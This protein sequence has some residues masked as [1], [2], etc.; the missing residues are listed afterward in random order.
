MVSGDY[1]VET[2]EQIELAYD[3]AG[4]GS[5][6]LA[7]IVDSALIALAESALFFALAQI[8]GAMEFAESVLIAIGAALGFAI[9]WGYY[10]A[11]ELTW[12]GQS[13]GKR[14]IG[15]RV[16]SEGGRPITVTGSIIRN[17]IRIVDFLP[18][19]YGIGVIAMFIDGQARRLGDLAAGTLVVRERADVTLEGLVT[20]AAP[21][22]PPPSGD[23]TDLID[24]SLLTPNDYALLCDFLDQRRDLAQ[25]VR[26]RL[27]AQ[28]GEGLQARLGVLPE[29]DPERLI[30][31]VARAYQYQRR[32][33]S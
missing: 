6:F 5:R 7:A 9:L 18:F 20:R 14:L 8:A 30:E 24:V 10:I 22:M 13:P 33:G 15:L 32:R 28:L 11:F 2:P 23:T 12:N 26:R 31:R 1:I 21:D 17:L 4:I 19:L 16:V 27:A 29:S 25:P 3:L